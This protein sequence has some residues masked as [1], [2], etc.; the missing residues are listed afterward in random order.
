MLLLSTLEAS[1]V[2]EAMRGWI[3]RRAYLEER[4]LSFSELGLNFLES[5]L[6]LGEGNAGLQVLHDF[7]GLIDGVDLVDVLGVLSDPGGV[8]RVSGLGLVGV[9]VLVVGDI[10]GDDAHFGLGLSEGLG[11]G[12]DQIVEGD[13]LGLVVL[14]FLLKVGDDLE[15]TKLCTF[16]LPATSVSLT[17]SAFFWSLLSWEAMLLRRIWISPTGPPVWSWSWRTER[18]ELPRGSALI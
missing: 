9:G 5:A 18:M 2:N 4:V 6:D 1:W 10:G 11:S 3:M 17:L 15:G 14:D 16:S 12:L 13:D 8:L 7:A